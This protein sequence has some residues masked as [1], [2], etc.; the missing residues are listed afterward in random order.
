MYQAV[1]MFVLDVVIIC[2]PMPSIW[3]LQMPVRRRASITV[4]F[5]LDE[6]TIVKSL[7][8]DS[9]ISG[10]QEFLAASQLSFDFQL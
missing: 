9:N 10:V 5:A 8:A 3:R 1:L 6:L 2:L 7:N 4:L